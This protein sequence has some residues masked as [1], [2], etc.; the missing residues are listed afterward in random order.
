MEKFRGYF[1]SGYS[2]K[3]ISKLRTPLYFVIAINIV[4]LFA[5][6]IAHPYIRSRGET[7][8]N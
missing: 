3:G 8:K 2:L 7:L 5:G 6:K 4:I 1:K